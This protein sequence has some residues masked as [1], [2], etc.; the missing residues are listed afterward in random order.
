MRLAIRAGVT[1]A[2]VAI[3]AGCGA[4]NASPPINGVGAIIRPQTS[5][6]A[7]LYIASSNTDEVY[8]AT[9]PG[10]R[11]P[12]TFK[13]AERPMSI[14]SDAKGNVWIPESE[15]SSGPGSVV[16]YAYGSTTPIATLSLGNEY[17]QDCAVDPTTGNLAVVD[18][19]ANVALFENAQG[20]PT[21]YSSVGVVGIPQ[22]VTYDS[23]GDLFLTA[24]RM[25]NYG[26]LP[27][28]GSAIERFH[29]KSNKSRQGL[30]WDGKYLTL[31]YGTTVNRYKINGSNGKKSGTLGSFSK[32]EGRYWI[33]QG[34]GLVCSDYPED[35]ASVYSYPSGTLITTISGVTSPWGITISVA[36]TSRK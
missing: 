1:G 13:T 8:V 19:N 24:R 16:E 28:G 7:L 25:N 2:L 27:H 17:P 15:Y 35:T 26:W 12:N 4:Q 21:F 29:I 9:Y 18:Y 23:A 36:P 5:S 30:Q 33:T 3:L 34:T 10:G 6:G 20:Q 32:C 14:C 31:M 22:L 11:I